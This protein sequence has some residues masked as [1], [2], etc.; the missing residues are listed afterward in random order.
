[1]SVKQ[2][3]W[4]L[5]NTH[6]LRLDQI[7]LGEIVFFSNAIDNPESC[8][9]ASQQEIR[10]V[11]VYDNTRIK[12]MRL[13]RLRVPR[14]KTTFQMVAFSAFIIIYTLV[15][16]AKKPYLTVMEVVRVHCVYWPL[17]VAPGVKPFII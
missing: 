4:H 7:W 12:F 9:N 6:P 16:F 14:Y 17:N 3:L 8:L 1:M 5:R 13:S 11:T 10:T 15:T 2:L